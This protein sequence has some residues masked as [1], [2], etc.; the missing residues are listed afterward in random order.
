MN[1]FIPYGRQ[2]ISEADIAAVVQVLQSDWL[3][4]GPM[5]PAFEQGVAGACG[6]SYGVAVNSA[7]S[8]LHIACLALGLGPGDRLWTVPNT[9]VASANCGRYC[10]AEVDFVDIDPDTYNLSVEALHQK[11]QIAQ[12]QGSLPKIVIPVHFA[13]QSCD[14]AAIYALSQEYNFRIIEDASHAVGGEYQGQPVG[15]CQYSDITVFSFHPV[16]IITTGEGG[17][18]VTNDPEIAAKMARLRT[19]GITRDPEL[20]SGQLQG[21]WVYAQVELGFNYRMTDLQAALG[22]SQ[23]Q[24]LPEFIARRRQLAAQ[25]DR[26]LA[27]MP[28]ILPWQHPDSLSAWHLYVVQVEPTAK[29]NRE[30]L[31]TALREGGI[32]VQVHYIPVHLQP[33]YR[34]LGF[35]VGDFPVAESYYGQAISLPMYAGLRDG[36]QVRV[37]ELLARATGT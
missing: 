4:Q 3:T 16:K 36:D 9:F 34:G 26:M 17:I 28:V 21:S 14:M 7:T 18:A 13:G 24:R 8:A 29:L 27:D 12:A 30:E 2:S 6:A 11:L 19:H 37:V 20:L 15:N 10:G 25:Y 22:L 5:V 32:G 35:Q 23:L 31:F 33:Y 1:P